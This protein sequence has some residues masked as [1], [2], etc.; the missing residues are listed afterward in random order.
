MPRFVR[1]LGHGPE[2]HA[3]TGPGPSFRDGAY[4]ADNTDLTLVARQLS[5]T[6]ET[7]RQIAGLT[8][9]QLDAVPPEGAF[10]FCDG[11]RTVEDVLARLLKHQDHQL[12]ALKAA[13]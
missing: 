4:T 10:R 13:I 2:G 3:G 12:D 6:R 1:S 11:Q 7:L 9:D 8:K 5:T